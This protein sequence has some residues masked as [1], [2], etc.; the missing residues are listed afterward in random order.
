LE[1]KEAA[2]KGEIL[3][4][5]FKVDRIKKVLEENYSKMTNEEKERD[6]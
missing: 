6:I 1:Q 2:W 5:F 3:L 4:P